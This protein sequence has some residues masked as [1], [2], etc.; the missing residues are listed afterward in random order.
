MNDKK[1]SLTISNCLVISKSPER[2]LSRI[3]LKIN[4]F[5][6]LK[7]IISIIFTFYMPFKGIEPIGETKLKNN[8]QEIKEFEFSLIDLRIDIG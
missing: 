1:D 6:V 5:L 2:G 7:I 3:S 4:I 8:I